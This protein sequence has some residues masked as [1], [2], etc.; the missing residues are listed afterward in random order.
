MLNSCYTVCCQGRLFTSL[1]EKTFLYCAEVTT[2]SVRFKVTVNQNSCSFLDLLEPLSAG[3]AERAV[4]SV[5]LYKV[6]IFTLR[7]FLQF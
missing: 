7:H 6:A 1:L 4:F 2:L 3:A 5:F